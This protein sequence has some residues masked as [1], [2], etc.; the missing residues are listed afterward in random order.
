MH[1]LDV[2]LQRCREPAFG[3]LGTKSVACVCA[4][5]IVRLEGFLITIDV[6][7]N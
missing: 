6:F 1:R 3:S 7:T 4:H 5:D 2:L